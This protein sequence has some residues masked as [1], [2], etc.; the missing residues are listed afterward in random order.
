MIFAYIF[1][2]VLFCL[3]CRPKFIRQGT[4]QN[5]LSKNETLPIKGLFVILVFFRHFRGYVD[6]D[7][8]LL[9]HLFVLLDSRSSQLI[10]TMFFF[11]SGYGIFEQLKKHKTYISSFIFHRFIPTYISFL[12]CVF[13]YFII[14][15]ISGKSFSPLD[16][17]LCFIGWNDSFGN[18]NWFMFVT[19]SLYALFYISFF[20]KNEEKYIFPK[21]IIFNILTFFLILLL[22]IYKKHY[23][24]N[25]LLCF[26]LGMFFSHF[27][28][29]IDTFLNKNSKTFYISFIIIIIL[30]LV[31]F[32]KIETQSPLFIIKALLFSIMFVMIEMKFTLEKSV[33]FTHLGK[34]VFSFY[35]LQRIPFLFFKNLKL[36][37]NIYLFFVLAFISTIIISL[38]YDYSFYKLKSLICAKIQKK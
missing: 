17:F 34:H 21:L 28:K 18:S 8:G 4:N 38:L 7:H 33:I 24:Y 20:Y 15:L 23:W 10:V 26:N 14:S 3:D 27:R 36:D 19:F 25:T 35:M 30:F 13:I 12:A 29:K 6:M 5:C 11:Y 9:N 31:S 16:I 37:N 1:L 22:A 32:F 2:F